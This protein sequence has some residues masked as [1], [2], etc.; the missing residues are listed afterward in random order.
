MNFRV[1]PEALGESI[2]AAVGY[3]DRE[4]LLGSDFLAE[5]DRSFDGIRH[6]TSSLAKLENYSGAHDIRRVFLKRFPYAVIVLWK[7]R[8]EL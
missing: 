6:E 3:D 7:P 4:P 2:E 5:V 1:L 8:N